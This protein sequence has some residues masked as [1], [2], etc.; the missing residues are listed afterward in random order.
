MTM[1]EL[2]IIPLEKKEMITI[3]KK[4]KSM[5]DDAHKDAMNKALKPEDMDKRLLLTT[6]F[7]CP[8]SI[9]IIEQYL[10]PIARLLESIISCTK[11][12]EM[13]MD[14]NTIM[15]VEGAQFNSIEELALHKSIYYIK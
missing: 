10:V 15:N 4:I 3:N 2:N 11:S 6:L 8:K 5:Y 1:S 14:H 7:V 9:N 12:M 13:A